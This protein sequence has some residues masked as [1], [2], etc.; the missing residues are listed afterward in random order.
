MRIGKLLNILKGEKMPRRIKF[1]FVNGSLFVDAWDIYDYILSH[2]PKNVAKQLFKTF[3]KA[4]GRSEE[5][6]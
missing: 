6:A 1:S 5:N 2:L 3:S 4:E